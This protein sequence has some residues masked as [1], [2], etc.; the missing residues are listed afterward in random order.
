MPE[1]YTLQP[2]GRVPNG[3]V[4]SAKPSYLVVMDEYVGKLKKTTY[5]ITMDKPELLNGFIQAKGIFV[6]SSITE[7]DIVLKYA[8]LLTQAA[9]DTI[10]EV[11]VPWHKICIIRSLVFKAK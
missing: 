4:I 2:V 7:E 5:F 10:L 8:T 3:S 11:L 6:D 9:R 1:D